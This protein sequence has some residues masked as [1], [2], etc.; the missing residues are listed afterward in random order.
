MLPLIKE[1]EISGIGV[2]LR[3]R[4]FRIVPAKR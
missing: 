4:H 3:E 2:P 1:G